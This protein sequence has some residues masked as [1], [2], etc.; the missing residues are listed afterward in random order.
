MIGILLITL[1]FDH[2]Y[3]PFVVITLT[4]DHGSVPFVVTT[5][6]SFPPVW[7][8]TRFVTRVTRRMLPVEHE[9]LTVPEH[10]RSSPFFSGV[11]G[12]R[13]LCFYALFCRSLFAP[14]SCFFLSLCC[15]CMSFD[16]RNQNNIIY[17]YLFLF[18]NL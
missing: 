2:G 5:I 9:L 13:S 7:L 1:T 17:K 4:F 11:R 14:L 3:V 18:F 6:Q 10:L 8:I 12:A 16:L 15:T